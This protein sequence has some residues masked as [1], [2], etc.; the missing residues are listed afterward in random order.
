[1]D[2]I[3]EFFLTGYMV[4]PTFLGTVYDSLEVWVVSN[5][6]LFLCLFF[7]AFLNED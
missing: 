1:M 2:D 3:V 6:V 7:V 5:L 4:L